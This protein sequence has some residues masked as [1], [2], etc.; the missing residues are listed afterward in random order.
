MS[1]TDDPGR[2]AADSSMD[3]GLDR[4]LDHAFAAPS[5]A[6]DPVPAS[7]EQPGD[8][9]DRYKLLQ[10]VGQGGMGTVWM[11]EQ[12]EP[13]RRQVA[14]KLVKLGMDTKEVIARFEAE[15]QA[16]AMMDHPNIAKVLDGGATATGRPYFVMELVRGVP[17]TKYCDEAR[18]GLRDRL[19]LFAR[20]CDAVQHAHLK[21]VI[22]RDLKP[23][24]VMVT[25]YDG[26]P[27]PKVIDFG[28]AKATSA[29]LTQKTMF[30]RY[31]AMIGTPEYMAPEQAEMSALDVD[32]R[33]DV[34]SLGVLLYELLTGT[35]PFE[36]QAVLQKGYQELIRT[37]REDDPVRPS[38]R[39]STLGKAADAIARNRHAD[40]ASLST[41]LRG[42][43]DW[44]V[45]RAMEKDRRRRYQTASSFADDVRRFLQGEPVDA[46]PASA[47]Y[48]T[49]KFLARHRR[50]VAFAAVV[51][52]LFVAGAIGSGLGWWN[53]HIANV[54]LGE[55]NSA[56]EQA[57]VDL[58]ETNTA[59]E[60]ANQA[61]TTAL[62]KE[63]LARLAAE[64][65]ER[66]E[67]RE[68]QNLHQIAEFQEAQIVAFR[69]RMVGADL[70]QGLL[71]SIDGAPDDAPRKVV[72]GY[73]FTES[74]RAS[75][76]RHLFDPMIDEMRRK[77]VDQPEV[78]ARLLNGAAVQ[79]GQFREPQRALDLYDEA[80]TLL[81]DLEPTDERA[82]L[83]MTIRS[84]TGRTLMALQRYDDAAEL[85]RTLQEDLADHPPVGLAYAQA[86]DFHGDMLFHQGHV[87]EALE[88]FRIAE[89]IY[90]EEQG[91]FAPHAVVARSSA[92]T[93][94][95]E[96]G[97]IDEAEQL[98]Q[99]YLERYSAHFEPRHSEIVKA[100]QT[101]GRILV[102]RGRRNEALPLLAQV[103]EDDRAIHGHHSD[104]AFLSGAAY[105]QC[106]IE[107][108]RLDEAGE[109]LDELREVFARGH[110]D[111][112][113][114]RMTLGTL[115]DL[116]A[117]R[118]GAALD[119]ERFRQILAEARTQFPEGGPAL[120][121][122]LANRARLAQQSGDSRQA[123]ALLREALATAGTLPD[124]H[125]QRLLSLLDL[126]GVLYD[127]GHNEQAI[128]V[129]R[130][131]IAQARKSFGDTHPRT[132]HALNVL[133]ITLQR[134][135]RFSEAADVGAEV[136]AAQ[137]ATRGADDPNTLFA[138]ANH[139][140]MLQTSG[141]R[142][143]A[144]EHYERALE[145]QTRVLGPTH[146]HTLATRIHRAAAWHYDDR[147]AEALAE[148]QDVVA[149][150]HADPNGEPRLLLYGLRILG[151]TQFAAEDVAAASASYREMIGIAETFQPGNV[152]TYRGEFATLLLR[153]DAF[154]ESEAL[155]DELLAELLAAQP[156]TEDEP[157]QVRQWRLH[158]HV[159]R[160]LQSEFQSHAEAVERLATGLDQDASPG[161]SRRS[162]AKLA[163]RF[164]T[165]WL[166]QDPDAGCEDRRAAWQAR[167]AE[168]EPR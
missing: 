73:D 25:L 126:G 112:A 60:E 14:L 65:A 143:E 130:S 141:R 157:P 19:E 116:Y 53:A 78:L 111:S 153:H 37:I 115:E 23:S 154:A 91:W 66:R 16:L 74:T 46:V 2:D 108:K 50:S 89:A 149:T 44:I 131:A 129:L 103:F 163:S 102:E 93:V 70:R 40:A 109:L 166:E 132:L 105:L 3:S 51:L 34:Y 86:N 7:A 122:F 84:S 24:N 45:M 29:E 64:E 48:R 167:A 150:I 168:L 11:A 56:L 38:T 161:S 68:R 32:T 147:N 77:F 99:E 27:M 87:A 121:G 69:P 133:A 160:A 20:V 145:G 18:L 135:G 159:V 139:G 62:E 97:R 127:L 113:K 31:G 75:M 63:R 58:G 15:R 92:L 5:P 43:I 55:T 36:L 137:I 67:A 47:S 114:L 10:E 6:G 104:A 156:A 17:I 134:L 72:A 110:A 59:L 164:Y 119:D 101:L 57:N 142:D 124:D 120:V 158:K 138:I 146:M 30:T 35:T 83:A 41:R 136:L 22:H 39:I 13:V 8:V 152:P 94:L 125:P 28:I 85:D 52:V 9:I 118:S 140:T 79:L 151:M 4:G 81:Y 96:L 71:E 155:I 54:A 128:E 82:G 80:L 165:A 90:T 21:G 106:L 1:R 61:K 33:S 144:L 162:A 12:H 76:V 117:A 100:R 123:E 107:L 88:A 49:R 42:E 26:V 95:V 148:V 98:A